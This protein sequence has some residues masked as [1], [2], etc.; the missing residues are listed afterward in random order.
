MIQERDFA[1]TPYVPIYV[2]LPVSC[3]TFF[4]WFLYFVIFSFCFL[5]ILFVCLHKTAGS[6]QYGL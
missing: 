4:F 3:K 6:Y 5:R 1:G 2:N